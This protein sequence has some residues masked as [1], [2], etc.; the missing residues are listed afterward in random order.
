[1]AKKITFVSAPNIV[2]DQNYGVR[3]IPLWAYTLA[4][5]VP[6]GWDVEIYDVE[7][8]GPASRV[9]PADVFAFSGLNKDLDTVR[10]ARADIKARYPDAVTIVGG[11]M[12]WSMEQE[13]KLSNLDCFDHIFI[14]SGEETLPAFLNKV[15]AG[16]RQS[17]PKVIH[18]ARYPIS[19]AKP[20]AFDRLA[21]K[22]G[23]Y[24]G[25]MIEV[26]R[27]CPFLCEF[28]D[29]RVQPGN[30]D[31]GNKSPDLVV[32]ELQ[33]FYELGVSQF[34]FIADNFLGNPTWAEECVDAIL[35][36]QERTGAK[37]SI[38]TWLTISLYKMPRLMEKMRRAGFSIIFVGIESVNN[39]ALME[40]A[41]VQNIKVE[42]DA[43]ARIIQSY[44]FVVIPGFIFGFDSDT[45][46]VF[47]DTLDFIVSTGLIGGEP[48]FLSALAGTPL[49]SRLK[50]SGRLIEGGED[51]V[52]LRKGGVG[53]DLSIESN[54]RYLQPAEFLTKGVLDFFRTYLDADWQYARYKRHLE[55]LDDGNFVPAPD[56]T[57]YA[58]PVKYFKFQLV[59]PTNRKMLIRRI[60]WILKRPSVLWAIL[61]AR[62]LTRSYAKRYPGLGFAFNY[63]I[64]VWTNMGMKYENL[65]EEHV[66][67]CSVGPDFDFSS[68]VPDDDGVGDAPKDRQQRR[69]TTQAL[70]DLAARGRQVSGSA[71]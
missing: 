67:L 41:K 49:Y 42:M 45:E 27:G 29:V 28:C 34:Q 19:R 5:H 46:T 18:G 2:Y 31:S 8:E 16:Q 68:L 3:L 64:Y 4:A 12:T 10:A 44:G 13:G 47:Q 22:I 50:K 32:Q 71:G 17:V 7:A 36:W 20:I 15:E 52:V 54:I 6:A 38:F 26:S 66:H 9:G 14:L 23:A 25:G 65:R 61:K 37:V 58:S 21:P 40:A 33:G 11:P 57:G 62:A 59:D 53:L 55:I 69:F 63:W 30:N 43:A 60:M 70:K 51:E 56:T 35:A 1:M 48:A 39:H 24:Y